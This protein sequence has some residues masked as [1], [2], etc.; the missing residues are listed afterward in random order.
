MAEQKEELE[1][2]K[3][4]R[5]AAQTAFTRR[6][7]YL[8]S[9]ATALGESEMVGEWRTFKSDHLR[10]RD[11]GFE[12]VTA[13]RE[14]EDERA[15]EIAE[16]IDKKTAECDNKFDETEQVV[17]KSFWTR[18]AEEA[19]TTLANEA[20]SAM[21]K[22]EETDYHQLSRKQCDLMNKSLERE[23]Y[24]LE[25]EVNDWMNLIPR[26]M[27]TESKDCVRKLKK[28]REKL[29]DEWAWQGNSQGFCLVSKRKSQMKRQRKTKVDNGASLVRKQHLLV[30]NLSLSHSTLITL[31]PQ[32]EPSSLACPASPQISAMVHFQ[33]PRTHHSERS[34]HCKV[35]LAGTLGLTM[36][37]P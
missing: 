10:V 14:A 9:R 21:D 28:R 1:R 12:Y 29:W 20:E 22:A 33:M 15:E 36:I 3:Q 2:L 5:S 16:Q 11:A 7:N 31:N 18:F 27:L 35:V 8:T 25:K 32:S 34:T 19:I 24:E 26:S 13:L 23:V 4:R 17:L 37:D 30:L 6:A